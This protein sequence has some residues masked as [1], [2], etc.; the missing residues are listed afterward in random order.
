MLKQ[1]SARILALKGIIGS[2]PLGT[3]NEEIGQIENS[4]NQILLSM[5]IFENP[6]L[7]DEDKR[8]AIASIRGQIQQINQRLKE[9]QTS[10]AAE[11]RK[12]VGS[13]K[14]SFEA[15]SEVKQRQENAAAYESRSTFH[16]LMKMSDILSLFQTLLMD[17]SGKLEKSMQAAQFSTPVH[18]DTSFDRDP[19]ASTLNP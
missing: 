13:K 10:T 14:A 11:Y 8:S 6:D 2:L 3:D 15:L 4:L 7:P 5:S 1:V 19:A 16:A 17:L 18:H 9:L 12:R